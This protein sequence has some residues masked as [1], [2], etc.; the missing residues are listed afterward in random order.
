MAF[1]VDMPPHLVQH[2]ANM[3]L[4]G[5]NPAWVLLAE[6]GKT[7]VRIGGDWGAY[8]D[9]LPAVGDAAESLNP[10][11]WNMFPMSEDFRLSQIETA[12]NRF[13]D[14]DVRHDASGACWVLF[15][16][17]SKVT[18]RFQEMQQA[19]N[20]LHLEY[21]RKHQLLDRHVGELVMS[22]LLDGGGLYEKGKR[23]MICTMFMDIR[24]FTVFNEAHDAQEV[25]ET[26]NQYLDVMLDSVIEYDGH[27]DKITGDGAMV[28]FGLK[29]RAHCV[30]QAF[31]SALLLMQ[32]V[33]EVQQQRKQHGR[34]V[35]GV[36]VG[37][38]SGEAVT[39]IVGTHVRRTF[40][41]FGRHVNLAARLESRAPAGAVLLDAASYH[42]LDD[43][44]H[45]QFSL[46]HI[47][48][49]GI[50]EVEAW[51]TFPLQA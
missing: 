8:C 44:R 26:V 3:H 17:V 32:R 6:D 34:A 25:L 24:N 2:L 49:K 48:A 50:G 5:L 28:V 20:T 45:C 1:P 9:V 30:Q 41:A 19:A 21:H 13:F 36:G 47:Q 15:T 18:R 10:V 16:D 31:D 38:A 37:I 29:H 22:D 51:E 35:L 14:I 27:V 23:R 4:N 40:T 39:G 7:I 43:R 46:R 33:A 11:L 42:D 12:D